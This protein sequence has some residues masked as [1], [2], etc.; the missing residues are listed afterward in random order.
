MTRAKSPWRL[1]ALLQGPVATAHGA[2]FFAGAT[3]CCTPQ[4]SLPIP[5]LLTN[6]FGNLIDRG[7]RRSH[8]RA[9]NGR[10]STLRPRLVQPFAIQ[11]CPTMSSRGRQRGSG[12]C[13]WQLAGVGT[14]TGAKQSLGSAT[15]GG[16]KGHCTRYCGRR[17]LARR[18]ASRRRP[19]S[20]SSNSQY[21]PVAAA[22]GRESKC[23]PAAIAVP[24]SRPANG[25]FTADHVRPAHL[26]AGRSACRGTSACPAH[27]SSEA[28][29]YPFAR[30]DGRTR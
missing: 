1:D 28:S 21:R 10:V 3:N 22:R 4:P 18:S 29:A 15:G 9:A 30:S 23:C 11:C 27:G 8:R 24:R 13:R 6:V 12:C 26:L 7:L 2:F 16:S 17:V 5:M 14:P 20:F 19:L 25:S